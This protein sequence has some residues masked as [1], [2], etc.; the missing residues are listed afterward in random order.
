M[1]VGRLAAGALVAVVL[2]LGLGP[3]GHAAEATA[4]DTCDLNDPYCHRFTKA[5]A[6]FNKL[7][8][9]ASEEEWLKLCVHLRAFTDP[10]RMAQV[11]AD[12]AQ[13]AEF[14]VAL[15]DPDAVH[16]MLRCAQKPIMWNTWMQVVTNPEKMMKAGFVVMNPFTYF[17]WMMAPVNPQMYANLTTFGD[18]H[19]WADWTRK[20]ADPTFFEPLYAWLNPQWSVERTTWAMD[21]NT[22]GNMFVWFTQGLASYAPTAG[23][24]TVPQ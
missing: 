3:T 10:E 15:S 22:Y 18:A 21:P 16:L 14:L 17:S 12:P 8:P 9:D 4:L 11:M 5:E 20:G 19:L 13:F 7:N 2:G 23:T 24:T 1:S 6:Y